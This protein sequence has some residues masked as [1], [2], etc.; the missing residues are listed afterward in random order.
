[1]DNG[2]PFRAGQLA[3]TC[4]VL[5]IRLI[6]AK[7]YSPE[8]KGKLERFHRYLRERFLTEA[9][10]V[11][12][13]SFEELNDRYLAWVEAVANTR[14]HAETNA[15][16][17]EAFQEGHSPAI[18][19]PA[20][21]FEAF[22]WSASRRVTKTATVELFANR[23]QVDPALVGRSVELRF[24]P[25]DLARID[26]YCDGVACGSAVPLVIG[27]RVHPGV[28]QAPEPPAASPQK[29]GVDYLGLVEAAH[30]EATFG[31][32][33]YRVVDL[34]GGQAVSSERGIDA[35]VGD[36]EVR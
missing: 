19:T 3:R 11:G 20:M 7:P 32:I 10:A 13:E 26:V 17:I 22:R 6:F 2:A 25:E 9:M 15:A 1:V 12:I 4:A 28:P 8:T 16:P 18:P 27:R 36:E 34:D 14:I 35:G 31:S 23:Y 21:L 29:G 33:A 24:D 30:E 5:G